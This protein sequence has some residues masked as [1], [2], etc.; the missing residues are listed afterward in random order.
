MRKDK[1]T[2]VGRWGEGWILTVELTCCVF[3]STTNVKHVSRHDQRNTTGNNGG[4]YKCAAPGIRGH[5]VCTYDTIRQRG[6][7]HIY[8]NWYTP[9]YTTAAVN[10]KN[11]HDVPV[12]VNPTKVKAFIPFISCTLA[13]LGRR[14]RGALSAPRARRLHVEGYP[15]F[16]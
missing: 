15:L 12:V 3:H 4:D 9:E 5:F 8:T 14:A 16:F 1:G 6:L 11:H 10:S 7:V 13:P 2:L